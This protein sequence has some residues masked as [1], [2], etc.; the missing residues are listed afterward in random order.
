LKSQ[1]GPIGG[2]NDKEEEPQVY[3]GNRFSALRGHEDGDYYVT[4]NGKSTP[5]LSARFRNFLGFLAGARNLHGR[6]DI[7]LDSIGKEATSAEVLNIVTMEFSEITKSHDFGV[8]QPQGAAMAE[9]YAGIF[10]R[11]LKEI[12]REKKSALSWQSLDI[13]TSLTELPPV[14]MFIVG[15]QF[16]QNQVGSWNPFTLAAKNYIARQFKNGTENFL[17]LPHGMSSAKEKKED[18]FGEGDDLEYAFGDLMGRIWPKQG[19]NGAVARQFKN[20]VLAYYAITQETLSRV[21]F[22]GNDR[23]S[24]RVETI[25][26]LEDLDAIEAMGI[27]ESEKSKSENGEKNSTGSKYV[28]LQKSIGKAARRPSIVSASLAAHVVSLD[29]QSDFPPP[30]RV[31]TKYENIPHSHILSHHFFNVDSITAHRMI[32]KNILE[33][34]SVGEIKIGSYDNGCPFHKDMQREVLFIPCGMEAKITGILCFADGPENSFA[35]HSKKMDTGSDS[36][37]LTAKGAIGHYAKDYTLEELE[38]KKTR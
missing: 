35:L 14:L 20:A 27:I 34:D 17:L 9:K 10:G 11:I 36:G 16:G 7:L 26:R 19:F 4:P 37:Q 5:C 24:G 30:I 25:F 12:I 28:L 32:G 13:G 23:R 6:I 22:T 2:G 21:D 15:I 38:C 1:R 33:V 31:I 8:V 29:R 18:K 3:M